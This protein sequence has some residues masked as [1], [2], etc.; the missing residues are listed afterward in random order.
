M[1]PAEVDEG[2]SQAVDNAQLRYWQERRAAAQRAGSYGADDLEYCERKVGEL[3]Q[4]AKAARPWVSRVQAATQ[5]HERAIQ[6]RQA[7]EADVHAARQALAHL[8]SVLHTAQAEESAAGEELTAVKAEAATQDGKGMDAEVSLD[9]MLASL[10]AAALL[11]GVGLDQL[12]ARLHPDANRA[13]AS[14]GQDP[15]QPVVVASGTPPAAQG[16]PLMPGAVEVRQQ[17]QRSRSRPRED[18]STTGSAPT[19]PRRR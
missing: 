10:R 2:D 12:A 17:H 16:T 11:A 3:L 6:Q 7:A 1:Q 19:T 4:A 18:R 13:A 5:R 9:Q 14:G 15:R 8:Q